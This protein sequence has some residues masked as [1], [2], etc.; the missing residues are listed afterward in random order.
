MRYSLG[1][2]IPGIQNV[3]R[4]TELFPESML[5]E[6]MEGFLAGEREES[7]WLSCELR[8]EVVGFCYAIAE[9]LTD[10]T[11]NMLALAV[12]PSSQGKGIGARSVEALE[13]D[14]TD[15][16]VRLLIVDTSGTPGFSATRR[17][18]ASCGYTEQSRIPGFW[19]EGDDKVTF[20]KQLK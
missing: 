8:G 5:P 14:L 2:D 20:I 7:V 17:F 9:P 6:M 3:L 13:R 15:R 4:E 10:G 11:W 16:G 19:A 12:H 1:E 18:Y